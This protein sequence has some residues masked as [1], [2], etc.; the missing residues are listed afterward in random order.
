MKSLFQAVALM[1]FFTVINRFLGFLFKIYLSRKIGAEALGVYQVAFS[2]FTVLVTFVATGLPLVI[3]KLSSSLHA[4]GE[5][6]AE[7][8]MVATALV[9]SLI[10]AVAT[11]LVVILFNNVLKAVFTDERC[12]LILILLL[13]AV[14]FSAI[15]STFRGGSGAG[16]TILRFALLTFLSRLHA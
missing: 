2:I 12:V 15:Y 16:Q 1:T 7:G 9:A 11:C 10:L 8:A 5:H 3:S 14:I 13:P 6:K 4:K